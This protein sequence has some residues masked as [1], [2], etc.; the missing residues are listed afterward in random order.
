VDPTSKQAVGRRLREIRKAMG[1]T[2]K[3]FAQRA[4]NAYAQ[5]E[6]GHRKPSVSM[7]GKF[8]ATYGLTLDFIY[9]GKR[10]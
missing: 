9:L 4:G 1:M 2:Q 6:C 8:T 7:A 10:K 3:E 5:Y